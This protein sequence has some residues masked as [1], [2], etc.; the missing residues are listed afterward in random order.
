M[1][2]YKLHERVIFKNKVSKVKS[3]FWWL[4]IIN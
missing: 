3:V 2:F 1:T 4:T